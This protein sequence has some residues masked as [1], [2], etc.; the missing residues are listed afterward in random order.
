MASD[1]ERVGTWGGFGGWITNAWDPNQGIADSD[2]DL[3]HQINANWVWQL[4][5]GTGRVI[6]TGVSKGW[7]R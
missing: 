1:A 4:P 7:M 2:F 6:G 3:R 5:F